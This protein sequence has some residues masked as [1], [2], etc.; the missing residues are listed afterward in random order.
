ML[1]IYL[2]TYNKIQTTNPKRPCKLS[3]VWCP[4]T[5]DPGNPLLSRWPNSLRGKETGPAPT[6]IRGGRLWSGWGGRSTVSTE[7]IVI[8]RSPYLRDVRTT[9]SSP[10]HTSPR[11]WPRILYVLSFFLVVVPF[12]VLRQDIG[13][14]LPPAG[15][16]YRDGWWERRKGIRGRGSVVGVPTHWRCSLM[17]YYLLSKFI[18]Y[19]WCFSSLCYVNVDI[20]MGYIAGSFGYIFLWFYDYRSLHILYV[21]TFILG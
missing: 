6:W 10:V 19:I 12:L 11:C 17:L 7:L 18:V 1:Y 2:C 21:V 13:K 15:G 9:F 20:C 5:T 16:G 8:S 3:P 4:N 14:T